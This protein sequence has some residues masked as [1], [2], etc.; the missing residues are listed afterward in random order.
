MVA[1]PLLILDTTTSK[2]RGEAPRVQR[3][4]T[5]GEVIVLV[6]VHFV[7]SEGIPS[8]SITTSFSTSPG[9]SMSKLI[10]LSVI[11]RNYVFTERILT[12]QLTPTVSLNTLDR[13]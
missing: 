5:V 3:R 6:G 9:R 1:Q 13:E 11:W 2:A 4:A 10:D 7:A 12:C 8:K